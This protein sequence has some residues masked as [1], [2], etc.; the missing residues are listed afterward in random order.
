MQEPFTFKAAARLVDFM[1]QADQPGLINLAAGVPGWDALPVAALEAAYREAFEKDGAAM[2]A[3]HHPEGDG[4][5]RDLI[6]ARLGQRG[7]T[8]R[9][10]D[11]VLTTGC[12]QALAVMLSVLVEPGDVVACEAPAYY[13]LLE[14]LDL[15]G[16]R[17]LP[18]PLLPGGAGL[19][20]D[21]AE[22]AF[23]RWKPKVAVVCTTLSNPSGATLDLPARKRLVEICRENGTRLLEDDIYGEFAD[24]GAPTLCRAFDDGSTVSVVT[25]FSKTVAP[26]LRIGYCLPGT[27]E[28]HDAFACR[29]TQQ[30][31]HSA[32]VTEVGLRHFFQ[33]GEMEPHLATLRER[34]RHRRTLALD[35]IAR[36][37]PAEA[38]VAPPCG[39]FM[40]WVQLPD[41]T[42]ML[43]LR[44]EA[45][46]HGVVFAAGQVFFPQ[47]LAP[48]G[49]QYFR[50]NCAKAGEEELV[51]GI[52]TLGRLLS[53]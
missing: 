7:V 32:V 33:R 52:E 13:G 29:K 36:S 19:D 31:L 43:R 35:A 2:L 38:I 10:S 15:F 51:R 27:P 47:R 16:A 49:P 44:D 41:G 9:G 5:L 12:T 21:A 45:R 14:L 18:I 48:E 20:L 50:L 24:D 37:F 1:R 6:A 30:D 46:A 22:T 17:V 26:G 3:Y 53:S 8:A 28:L 39:G 25:S 23:R 34:N 11:L 40:L 42:D 4:P